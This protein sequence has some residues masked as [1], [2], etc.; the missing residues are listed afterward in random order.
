MADPLSA[1]A[2]IIAIIQISSQVLSHCYLFLKEAN[3]A[4][5]DI[6]MIISQV[7][8]VESTLRALDHLGAAANLDAAGSQLSIL[9]ELRKK[10]GPFETCLSLLKDLEEKLRPASGFKKVS[11]AMT[12]P[13]KEKETRKTLDAIERH[14]STFTLALTGDS[15]RLISRLQVN[16][17]DLH[18]TVQNMERLQM[19]LYDKSILQW[20]SPADYLSSHD[21]ARKKHEPTTGA[22]LLQSDEFL[23]WRQNHNPSMWLHGIPGCGKTILCSTII[24][25]V[26]SLC[27]AAPGFQCAYFYFEFDDLQKQ[28]A[29]SFLSTIIVQLIYQR[30]CMPEVMQRLYSQHG[31][32]CQQAGLS[33][34]IS[35]ILSLIQE[36][37]QV[38]LV[39]DALDECSERETVLNLIQQFMSKEQNITLLV[40]SRN[41]RD[42]EIGLKDVVTNTLPIQSAAVNSDIGLYVHNCIASDQKLKRWSQN[43]REEIEITLTK[44]AEGM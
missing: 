18:G 38:F 19:S 33:S 4:S 7:G 9:D 11:R 8:S 5:K 17:A 35:T 36:S 1:T 44:G 22:W 2:S 26:I 12:W 20:L 39:I 15:A 43:V 3:N 13:L 14:K 23:N 42:I 34:L 32:G 16:V 31:N 28:T 21:A 30:P 27:N 37:D 41:E 24:D 29:S 40:T 6:A 10:G 25:H